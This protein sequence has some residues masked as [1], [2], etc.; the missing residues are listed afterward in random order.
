MRPEQKRERK[1]Y[2]RVQRVLIIIVRS[3]FGKTQQSSL[4]IILDQCY[5]NVD[6]VATAVASCRWL[7][8]CTT[9][10]NGSRTWRVQ[11]AAFKMRPKSTFEHFLSRVT[12]SEWFTGS[13]RMMETYKNG[14]VCLLFGVRHMHSL[15]EPILK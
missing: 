1:R 7:L 15:S 6:E 14:R 4:H 12:K 2:R 5:I 9:D 10:I 3:V 13:R 11:G 8:R